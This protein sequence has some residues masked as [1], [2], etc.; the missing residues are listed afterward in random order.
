M[1]HATMPI[2]FPRSPTR[3]F[4]TSRTRPPARPTNL[5]TRNQAEIGALGVGVLLQDLLAH[6]ALPLR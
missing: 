4:S 2:L 1:P 5:P 6:I 3:A